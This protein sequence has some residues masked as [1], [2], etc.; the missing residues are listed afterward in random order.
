MKELQRR[1]Q[2]PAPEVE[3]ASAWQFLTKECA[4][5]TRGSDQSASRRI[6]RTSQGPCGVVPHGAGI[7]D[8]CCAAWDAR[9]TAP[10][11]ATYCRPSTKRLASVTL[12]VCSVAHRDRPVCTRG[13]GPPS[14][15]AGAAGG[16]HGSRALGPH[17]D[18]GGRTARERSGC[19]R[20]RTDGCP[21][22]CQSRTE[23]AWLSSPAIRGWARC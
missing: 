22:V 6:G 1:P 23:L 18:H 9:A 8:G 12:V 15:R 17:R 4:L 3:N 14:C 19:V 11:M 16:P 20:L 13:S 7:A 21:L 2:R 5:R 10:S